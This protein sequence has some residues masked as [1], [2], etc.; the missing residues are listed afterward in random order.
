[1]TSNEFEVG[2]SFHFRINSFANPCHLTM[3]NSDN[4]LRTRPIAVGQL[5]AFE[6]VARYLNFR[7][8]ADELSLTQSAVSRRFSRLSRKWAPHFSCATPARSK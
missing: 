3:Q 6:A 2:Y 8:A 4:T 7:V 5:R 1:M